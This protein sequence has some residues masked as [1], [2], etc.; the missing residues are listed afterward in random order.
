MPALDAFS[1]VS[2]T[3]TDPERSADFYNRVLGTETVFSADDDGNRLFIVARAGVTIALRDHSGSADQ[4]FDPSRIGLDH[5]AFQ[6]GSEAELEAWETSLQANGVV[7][8]GIEAS[9]FGLH[10]NLKDPDDIAIELFVPK[11]A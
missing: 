9:P 8:S 2:L 3:V 11:P 4:G 5:I 10:L 7:C 1:H 6:V